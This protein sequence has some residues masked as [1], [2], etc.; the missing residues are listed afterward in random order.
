MVRE[1]SGSRERPGSRKRSIALVIPAPEAGA[2]RWLLVQRPLDD[3]ELPGVWGLPAAT[4]GPDE[5]PEAVVRRIGRD[6]LG[7]RLRPGRAV[8]A[9]R[10]ERPGYELEMELREAEIE[11]GQPVVPGSTPGV[12]QYRRFRWGRP[13]DLAPGAERGSLCCALALEWSGRLS[14]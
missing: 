11:S 3:A 5:T 12:T 8:I 9:G 10:A 14:E 4:L 2:R 13:R 6:K 7:V 1:G